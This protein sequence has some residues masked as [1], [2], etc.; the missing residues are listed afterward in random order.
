[1]KMKMKSDTHV[2]GK[3]YKKGDTVDVD[4]EIADRWQEN[5]IAE[6]VGRRATSAASSPYDIKDEV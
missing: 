2:S 4:K 5:G 3:P 6:A 1:M